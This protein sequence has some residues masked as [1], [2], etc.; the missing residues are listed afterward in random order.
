MASTSTL[1]DMIT[2]A[3]RLINVLGTGEVPSNDDMNI[4][5]SAL[6]SLIDSWSNNRLM[7]Y[8]ISP[9]TFNLTG[10]TSYTI[11]VGGDW[12]IDRPMAIESAYARLNSGSAQQV[13]IPMQ[14]LTDAQYAAITVKNTTSTFAFSYYDNG[15]YPLRS[16]Y[17]FPIPAAGSQVVLWLRQPLVDLTS[18]DT[19]I[20]YPPGYERAFRFNLA[21]ELAAE[22][23]KSIPEQVAI[24]S[25][26]SKLEI[27]RLNSTPQYLRGDHGTSRGKSNYFNYL[28]GNFGT[29]GN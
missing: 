11:G 19:I 6:D 2:G 7:I 1:R 15:N 10:A 28:T 9:Y 4:A 29:F 13:D 17:L 23:G 24:I 18:L 27:E 5:L 22:F 26:N 8:T 12:N 14:S 25:I 3:M 16:I 20:S 21:V